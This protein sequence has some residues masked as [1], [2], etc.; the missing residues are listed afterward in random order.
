LARAPAPKE[1]D[2]SAPARV[3][4]YDAARLQSRRFDVSDV[5]GL[6]V[7][8]PDRV[9]EV[10]KPVGR[11]LL[12]LA[13]AT[14]IAATCAAA[15]FGFVFY[16]DFLTGAAGSVV[17]VMFEHSALLI[18]AAAS[19]IFGVLLVGYGYMSRGLRRKAVAQEP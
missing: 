2:R 7:E 6:V 4:D 12:M 13:V 3:V 5:S 14:A 16:A 19:P 18:I 10:R 1:G 15:V 8:S 9:N 11:A 17:H